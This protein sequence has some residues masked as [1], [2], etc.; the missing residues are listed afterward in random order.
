MLKMLGLDS[1]IIYATNWMIFGPESTKKFEECGN[2]SNEIKEQLRSFLYKDMMRV[3]SYRTVISVFSYNIV[4]AQNK[5]RYEITFS[6]L[7]E[8]NEEEFLNYDHE[9][10]F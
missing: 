3:Y 9:I 6:V 8:Q 10:N 2:I 5:V 4:V 1:I 7:N